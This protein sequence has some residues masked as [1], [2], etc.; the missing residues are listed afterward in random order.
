MIPFED[1]E[2]IEGAQQYVRDLIRGLGDAAI[3]VGVKDWQT[4]VNAYDVITEGG[5]TASEEFR[6]KIKNL[7]LDR[8]DH[9]ERL[10]I[11]E[12]ITFRL[13]QPLEKARHEE[14]QKQWS[15]ER[16]LRLA[17]TRINKKDLFPDAE[18]RK[19]VFTLVEQL[20]QVPAVQKM[21]V[22]SLP[23]AKPTII[24]IVEGH[25]GIPIQADSLQIICAVKEAFD[26]KTNAPEYIILTKEGLA[27]NRSVREHPK[28]V[29]LLWQKTD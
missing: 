27:G 7:P 19:A 6:G 10:A 28:K 15:R 20:A 3:E 1:P 2:I 17:K 8:K 26:R 18:V 4:A 14:E 23:D 22:S 21:L 24:A 9:K 11:A 5:I 13:N 16:E 25:N 12:A 29:K